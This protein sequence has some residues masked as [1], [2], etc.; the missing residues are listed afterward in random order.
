MVKEYNEPSWYQQPGVW[1]FGISF[2]TSG[3]DFPFRWA[4]GRPEDLEKRII[5][6]NTQYYLLPGHR[7][8]VSGCIE[9]DAVPPVNTQFW[10]GGLIQEQVAIANDD[11]DRIS[12][13]VGAP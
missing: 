1:R 11:V 2:D 5:D 6:G 13:N 12:V 10:K 7:G 4:V 9:F 8:Q 3:T